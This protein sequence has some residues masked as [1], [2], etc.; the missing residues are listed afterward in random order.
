MV[1]IIIEYFLAL[2]K[3]ELKLAA[4]PVLKGNVKIESGYMKQ[5]THWSDACQCEMTFSIFLPE[6]KQRLDADPPVLYYL[7]G[8]FNKIFLH[9]NLNFTKINELFTVDLTSR[10]KC[11]ING[12]DFFN[13][14]GLLNSQYCWKWTNANPMKIFRQPESH[15]KLLLGSKLSL[16]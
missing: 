3:N 14:C 10:S 4:L 11:Q 7:S 8:M 9:W 6:R 12:E 15:P 1:Y 16:G 2:A 13:F 5:F